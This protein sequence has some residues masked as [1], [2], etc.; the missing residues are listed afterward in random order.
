MRKSN[1]KVRKINEKVMKSNEKVRKSNEKVRKTLVKQTGRPA[2][3]DRHE[4]EVAENLVKTMVL[5]H[6]I[7]KTEGIRSRKTKTGFIY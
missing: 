6:R 5:E 1:E 2:H 3:T 7:S 4:T